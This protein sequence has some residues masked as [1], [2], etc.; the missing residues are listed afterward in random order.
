MRA[1]ADPV[2]I[3]EVVLRVSASIGYTLYPHDNADADQLLRHADQAMYSAKQ[4]GR[5]CTCLFDVDQD[6]AV[7][8][9]RETIEHIRRAFDR[10]EFVLHYQPRVN[11]KTGRVVGAEALIRWQHP[12]RG[13]L[14]PGEFLP[15]VEN[16][17]L[18]VA[19]GGWVINTALRQMEAWRHLGL[20]I[21]VSVNIASR[22]MQ[23]ADF[24][25]GLRE[26]LAVHPEV[27]P[28][29]LELEVLE[30]SLL[31]DL[32]HAREIMNACRDLGVRFALD[33]FGTGYSSLTYLRRLPADILKIDQSFVRDM[34]DDPEDLAIIEGVLSLAKAFR[35]EV[36]AEGVETVEHGELLILMGCEQ[37]QGFGI[38]RPMP[39]V[40]FA[41]W[42]RAW[43]PDP[44]WTQWQ[45]R[46]VGPGTAPLLFAIVEHRHWLFALQRFLRGERREP[47]VLDRLACRFCAWFENEGSAWYAT[48][49]ALQGVMARHERAHQ[50]GEELLLLH[51]RGESADV[52]LGL[53]T[54][55][56]LN[57]ELTDALR[58]IAHDI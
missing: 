16:R 43:Q 30:T 37:A 4:L 36:V 21:P 35:R 27:P 25:T 5:N 15:V 29:R 11:M 38:A 44:A 2:E 19:I 54:L 20:D 24:V 32:M 17:P 28:S 49:P 56:D 18:G 39:A 42:A 40:D 8:S 41:T 23:H 57:V 47:P 52:E 1:A 50:L 46:V 9:Q 13:L 3:D 45:E 33:D 26:S 34:L 58:I 48:D 53:N 6:A 12:Q 14:L 51:A 31:D 10:G 7:Q 55:H 22:Q